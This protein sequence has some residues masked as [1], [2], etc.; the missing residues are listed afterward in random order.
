MSVLT[1]NVLGPVEIRRDGE[2]VRIYRQEARAL[3]VLVAA[4]GQAVSRETLIA[5]IWQDEPG[6]AQDGLATIMSRLRT[7]LAAGGLQIPSAKGAGHY[8]L[9]AATGHSLDEA[10]DAARFE[11][12]RRAGAALAAEGREADALGSFRAAAREWRGEPLSVPGRAWRPPRICAAFAAD[13]DGQRRDL[14]AKAT[15]IALRLGRYG[16][17]DFLRGQ[18]VAAGLESADALWL[19]GVLATLRAEGTA[20]A[21]RV[22]ESRQP[23]GYAPVVNRALDLMAL[24]RAGID[25][26]HPLISGLPADPEEVAQPGPRALADFLARVS[27]GRPATLTLRGPASAGKTR[28]AAGLARS[29]AGTGTPVAAVSCQSHGELHPWRALAGLLW[30]NALRDVGKGADQ[31]TKAHQ[32]ALA[33]FVTGLPDRHSAGPAHQRDLRDLASALRELLRLAADGGRGLIVTFDDA[34][35][36]TPRGH[37]LLC[38]VRTGLQGVAVGWL[39]IGR[40]TGPWSDIPELARGEALPSLDLVSQEGQPVDPRLPRPDSKQI[41]CWLAAAAFTSVDLD[42]DTGLV[43]EMLALTGAESDRLLAEALLSGQV[44]T[45]T[46]PRFGDQATRVRLAAGL[47]SDPSSARWLHRRAF[48]LLSDRLRSSP[49]PDPA[50]ACRIAG[51]ARE[52]D[53]EVSEQEVAS[54]CLAAARAE[55]AS[56]AT[57]AAITWAKTGLRC[58]CDP[59]TRFDLLLALGD[60]QHDGGD[61]SAAGN[62]YLEAYEQADGDPCRQAKAAIHMARRWSDPGQSDDDLLHLIRTSLGALA[63]RTDAEAT[64][65]RLQLTAHLAHKSSMAVPDHRCGPAAPGGSGP[66]LARKALSGLTPD[67][68][69][70]AVCEVLNECRWGL[71][72]HAPPAETLE[73]AERFL[74]ASLRQRSP[75]FRS[76]ALVALAIDQLRV[77]PVTRAED[78]I[79]KHRRYIALRPRA[80]GAWLQGTLDTVLDLWHG[81]FEAAEARIFGESLLAVTQAQ[82][83]SALPADTL[84]QT[85]Q[86]QAYW[87]LREQGRMREVVDSAMA[88]GIADHGYFPIWRAAW[89]LACCDTGRFDEA[90]DRIAALLA[91]TDDLATLP[92]HGWAVPMLAL[93]AEACAVL[94]SQAGPASQ[95][96]LASQAGPASDATLAGDGARAVLPPFLIG[97]LAELLAPHAGEIALAGWPVV[98]VG[99]VSRFTGLLALA[100]G[101]RDKALRD[102]DRALPVVGD[103]R[104]Q[105]IRLKLDKARALLAGQGAPARVSAAGLAAQVLAEAE[106]LGMAKLAEEAKTLLP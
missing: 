99:P 97:R 81:R 54:A 63:G 39:L 85:W 7:K 5:A 31:M 49:W 51:H 73:I 64:A 26:H 3:A 19:L 84:Q 41:G 79:A 4:R 70:S 21:E 72:D 1:I 104:P 10:V 22:I 71:Y 89:I 8:R 100:A 106:H 76:E 65:R 35:L 62:Q 86:G 9:I 95:A 58:R 56:G 25:V 83:T 2:P 78:T 29:A 23:G 94:A 36:M 46:R 42:I 18:P 96:G 61:M 43:A 82:E 6:P 90:S 30:A 55:Q 87:L 37:E 103:A 57:A 12:S 16:E 40:Q 50:L 13:L 92:P 24:A 32:V 52:A 74:Q 11:A 28:L 105:V 67:L 34:D 27:A 14:V 68:P 101:D 45:A 93:L 77:G 66:E 53:P 17:A 48:D 98:L 59:E 75:F 15:Q 102:F 88:A 60:A 38:D 20:A 33:D 91:D 44:E 80:L 69:A 47:N